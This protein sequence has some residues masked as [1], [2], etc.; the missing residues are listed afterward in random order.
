MN[1]CLQK[2]LWSLGVPVPVTRD[3]PFHALLDGN[4]LLL[5]FDLSLEPV[6][7]EEVVAGKYVR[8]HDGHFVGV[9]VFDS[10]ILVHEQR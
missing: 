5:D 4:M 10:H 1:C 3:G 6:L 9:E 7:A 8:W 2:S